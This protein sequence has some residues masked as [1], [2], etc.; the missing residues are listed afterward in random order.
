VALAATRIRQNAGYRTYALLLNR[1]LIEFDEEDRAALSA[2]TVDPEDR[3]LLGVMDASMRLRVASGP[4]AG[5]PVRRIGTHGVVGLSRGRSKRMHAKGG[6]FDLHAGLLVP[7]ADRK[8]L[9]R[10]SRYL[11]R[12]ALALERLHEVG[13]DGYEWVLKRPW[14]D[15]T[16][17]LR[18]S[19]HELMEKLAVLVPM[20]RANLVRY[21]GVLAPAARWRRHVVPRADAEGRVCGHRSVG[22]RV[23]RRRVSWAQLLKR[24][25]IEDV[26]RCRGCGGPRR[27]LAEVTN[28]D[29][30]RAILTHLGIDPRTEGSASV[31]GPPTTG[32]FAAI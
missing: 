3:L 12:P 19:G 28:P 27:L 23:P 17:A 6:G 20:P 2:T 29:A 13:E 7:R 30:V 10:V 8:R 31:R 21:H 14:A 26:L 24:V 32:L 11:L 5:K 18:F 22:G 1:G 25:F 9:E 4:R 15:G 16:H